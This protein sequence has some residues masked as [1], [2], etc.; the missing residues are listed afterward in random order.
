MKEVFYPN[1]NKNVEMKVML[2]RTKS[3]LGPLTSQP[4]SNVE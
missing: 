2:N 3:D 1:V 4:D